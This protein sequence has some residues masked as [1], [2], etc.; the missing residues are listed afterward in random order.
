LRTLDLKEGS[1][2]NTAYPISY[3]NVTF[4]NDKFSLNG[5]EV[6]VTPDRND[7]ILECDMTIAW[8]HNTMAFSSLPISRAYRIHWDNVDENGY[9]LSFDPLGGSY[10]NPI[11]D[12]T[13][14]WP[15]ARVAPL[16]ASSP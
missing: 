9:Q 2:A 14:Y 15:P 16:P 1:Y 10:A 3:F 4:T 5:N 12:V 13:L 7:H 11:H 8:R 6:V